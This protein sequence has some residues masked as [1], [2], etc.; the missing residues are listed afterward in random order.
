MA[1]NEEFVVVLS[2]NGQRL[3]QLAA[4]L[5]EGK[6]LQKAKIKSAL[7]EAINALSDLHKD[8]G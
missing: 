3:L 4:E 1:D 7:L 2:G 6:S 8:L 5:Q